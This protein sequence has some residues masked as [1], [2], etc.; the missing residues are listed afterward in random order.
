MSVRFPQRA[1]GFSLIELNLVVATIA[2]LAV[3]IVPAA[4]PQRVEQTAL[5]TAQIR[6]ALSFA[7][8]Q[9]A[10][11]QAGYGVGIDRDGSRVRVFRIVNDA[12]GTPQA[13]YDVTHPVSRGLF[14]FELP[15]GLGAHMKWSGSGGAQPTVHN[16]G[17]E[18]CNVLDAIV[19]AGD[20]ATR[21]LD[22]YGGRIVDLHVEVGTGRY[23]QVLKVDPYTAAVSGP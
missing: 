19:F 9:A 10:H 23:S 5:A 11:R 3:M 2:V 7:R 16:D 15:A 13:T 6:A 8:D 12:S 22:P 1:A 18:T 21:C 4:A 14:G 20:A 17:I